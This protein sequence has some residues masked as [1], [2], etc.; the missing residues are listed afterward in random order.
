[1]KSLGEIRRIMIKIKVKLRKYE[2]FFNFWNDVKSSTN[3]IEALSIIIIGDSTT[4]AKE[5]ATPNA[6]RLNFGKGIRAIMDA[7]NGPSTPIIN[8]VAAKGSQKIRIFL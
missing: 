6:A 2:K 3:E 8:Q 7:I 1:M 4:K 5:Y